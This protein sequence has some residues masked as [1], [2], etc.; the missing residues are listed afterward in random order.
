MKKIR[1]RKSIKWLNGLVSYG[2]K[3]SVSWLHWRLS[4]GKAS[5]T[6][7]SSKIVKELEIA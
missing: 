1:R 3:P 5:G 2:Y 6:K 4:M 7:L